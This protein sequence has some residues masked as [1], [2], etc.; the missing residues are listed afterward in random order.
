MSIRFCFFSS[1]MPPDIEVGRIVVGDPQVA[2]KQ[3]HVQR[4]EGYLK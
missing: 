1:C 3:A 2:L 4:I